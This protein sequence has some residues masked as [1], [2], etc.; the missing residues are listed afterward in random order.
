MREPWAEPV[1]ILSVA[2]GVALT[3]CHDTAQSPLTRPE[4]PI[5]E[6][7]EQSTLGPIDLVYVC[8]N[9]FLA[10]NSTHN[11][12]QVE[13][14]VAGTQETGGLTLDQ[15]P[16]G[17]PGYSETELET[18]QL[19]AVEL[20]HEGFRVARRRNEGLP[21]GT[22][23]T[24]ASAAAGPEATAGKWGAPFPWPIVAVHL[25]L[26]PDARV[27]SWGEAGE[28][29]VW[30]P[31][32]KAFTE[33]ALGTELFCSGH[34]FLPDGRLLVTGGHQS[35][36]HGLPDVNFFQRSTT[37]WS[38]GPTM[39]K[40]RWYPTTIT[41]GSGEAVTLAGTDLSARNVQIP[42]VWTG[43][44]WRALIG[45]KRALQWYPRSFLAPN[46]RVFHAGESRATAYLSTSG[47]GSWSSV[48]DRLYGSR[49]YGA[50]VM[51]APGKVLYAGG[52]YTT[53]TAET[54]DLNQTAPVW[55]WTGRMHYAR[56]HLNATIL[57]TGQVLV[58][59][60]TAGI[61][62]NDESKAVFAAELWDPATGTWSLLASGSII[63]GYHSTAVLLRDG[64]VLVTGSGD[65]ERATNQLSAELYSPPYLFKGARPVISS[66]P[67]SLRYGQ[68]VFVGTAQASTIR[69]VTL[70]RLGSTTHAFNTNQ[71]FNQ[72]S[73]VATTG[74]VNVTLPGNRN[75]APP[76]H[77][78][79]FILTG[80]GVPS[81][82]KIIQLR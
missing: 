18:A 73:F 3:G 36:S 47:V 45:A 42:E 28:P 78:I 80:N 69:K 55:K 82:G 56:R 7:P 34:T 15:G 33:V 6:G 74:G 38:S 41:L 59:G 39:A 17:D 54:I 64:R 66:S 1:L 37:T 26:L 30:D 58:T 61:I 24:S 27:L 8:G 79:L 72:L 13:Y 65:S 21:C 62:H 4:P 11:R 25:S 63:R 49:N 70:V 5:Q 81:T 2:A 68:T 60:G 10:T 77:Y 40:G 31:V 35:D 23:S 67:T 19:G 48:G 20:Y 76:G 46:G 43:S 29:Q 22:A 75:L 44:G 52:G 12:V 9:K 16:G 71:R 53:N 57:P 51:Y 14:R 32:S 50:A